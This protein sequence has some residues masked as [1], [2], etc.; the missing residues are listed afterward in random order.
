M[1]S[2][3]A[4]SCTSNKVWAAAQQ[5]QPQQQVP[6]LR[7]PQAWIIHDDQPISVMI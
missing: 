6:H 3:A 4:Q 7:R 1:Q 2:L 5:Q